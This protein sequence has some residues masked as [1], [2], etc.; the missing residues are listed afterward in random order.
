MSFDINAVSRC[1]VVCMSCQS[2]TAWC[3]TT[4]KWHKSRAHLHFIIASPIRPPFFAT[5]KTPTAHRTHSGARR[6]CTFTSCTHR[7]TLQ[8]NPLINFERNFIISRF[9][10]RHTHTQTRENTIEIRNNTGKKAGRNGRS[11]CAPCTRIAS[12]RQ[13]DS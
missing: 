3:R 11:A 12:S 6:L 4:N 1:T 7:Y 2:C 9:R 10:N 5:H 13:F 8:L